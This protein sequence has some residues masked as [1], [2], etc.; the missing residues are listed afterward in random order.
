MELIDSDKKLYFKIEHFLNRNYSA[1]TNSSL[2]LLSIHHFR[3]TALDID[4]NWYVWMMQISIFLLFRIDIFF[5]YFIVYPLFLI[6]II[7]KYT[8]RYGWKIFEEHLFS[9][10]IIA[11]FPCIPWSNFHGIVNKYY[12]KEV[13][14][15][16]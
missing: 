1:K 7:V 13:V 11:Y 15:H 8:Y 9:Q 5:S 14:I 10:V 6:P 4:S 3:D 12:G 2:S 16:Y